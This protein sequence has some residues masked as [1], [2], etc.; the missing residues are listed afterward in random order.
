M[1]K[2]TMTAKELQDFLG[3]GRAQA[4]ELCASEGFPSFRIGRKVLISRRGLDEW[5]REREEGKK[6]DG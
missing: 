6:N 3:I 2:G 1:D 5:M 4:Y